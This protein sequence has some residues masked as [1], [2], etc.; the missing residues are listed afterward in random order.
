MFHNLIAF[1]LVSFKHII[2]V[3]KCLCPIHCY[4]PRVA[5]VRDE[6]TLACIFFLFPIHGLPKKVT[7]FH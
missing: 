1:S 2:T 7:Y 5:F 6:V 4:C 3:A